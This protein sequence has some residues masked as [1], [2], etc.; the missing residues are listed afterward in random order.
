MT[1]KFIVWDKYKDCE[2]D[3]KKIFGGKNYS[4]LFDENGDIFIFYRDPRDGKICK[5]IA[6][7]VHEPERFEVRWVG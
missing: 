6:P 3:I 7:E 5:N 4:P 2:A 1:K